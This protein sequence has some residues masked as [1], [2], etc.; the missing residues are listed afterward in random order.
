MTLLQIYED[1]KALNGEIEAYF[2]KWTEEG[3]E[4]EKE[5][6]QKKMAAKKEKLEAL[7]ESFT[8]EVFASADEQNAKDLKYLM[9]DTLFLMMDMLHF[10]NYEDLGRCKMRA[11]NYLGKRRRAEA[12][13]HFR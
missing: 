5:E 10:S 13:L 2:A 9:M 3:M 7:L 8:D 4:V 11:V 12:Q 6:L 1:Y